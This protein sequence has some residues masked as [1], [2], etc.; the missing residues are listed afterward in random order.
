MGIADGLTKKFEAE[1]CLKSGGLNMF[2]ARPSL[3]GLALAQ[4]R[5]RLL[6]AHSADALA[7]AGSGTPNE[8]FEG[9]SRPPY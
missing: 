9:W 8:A 4:E 5:Y 6:R 3:A 1:Q 7:V 2:N